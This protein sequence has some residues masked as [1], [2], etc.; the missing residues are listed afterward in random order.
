MFCFDFHIHSSCS[1]DSFFSPKQIIKL[2]HLKDLNALA[3]TDHNTIKGGVQAKSIKQDEI[4]VIIGSEVNTN[5]GDLIGLFLNEEIKS[6]KFEEVVDEIREQDGIV[7][8]PHP[9]R[10]KKIPGIDLLKSVD[11][12]EG[13]N[14][15]TSEKLNLKAQKLAKELKKPIIAGSDAHFSF[16]LGRVWNV[17]KTTSDCDEEELRKRILNGEIEMRGEGNNPLMRKGSIILGT[18]IKKLRTIG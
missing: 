1:I 16:E 5:F 6:R 11:I 12:I 10:R 4:N 7:Y 14:A 13:I 18:T 15:R 17:S 2:A 9:Y 3:I 8:L